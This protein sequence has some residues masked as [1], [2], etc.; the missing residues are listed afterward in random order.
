MKSARPPCRQLFPEF[1]HIEHPNE[2]NIIESVHA[3]KDEVHV[4][5]LL[6]QSKLIAANGNDVKDEH[7]EEDERRRQEFIPC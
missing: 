7:P 6:R 5:H 4:T 2:N 1:V 3:V